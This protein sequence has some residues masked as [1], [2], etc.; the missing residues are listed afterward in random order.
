MIGK[1]FSYGRDS[2]RDLETR[3]EFIAK[4]YGESIQPKSLGPD[5]LCQ[6]FKLS[7]DPVAMSIDLRLLIYKLFDQHVISRL[8]EFY[9]ALNNL[10]MS[11]GILPKI[12]RAARVS[13]KATGAQTSTPKH[14]RPLPEAEPATP[15][16]PHAGAI[17]P[18]VVQT[19]PVPAGNIVGNVTTTNLLST[20]ESDVTEN[21]DPLEWATQT[22]LA[23]LLRSQLGNAAPLA[24]MG[25]AT[26]STQ[27]TQ[28]IPGGTTPGVGGTVPTV[29]GAGAQPGGSNIN[30]G[31]A[32]N[33]AAGQPAGVQPPGAGFLAGT[34]SGQQTDIPAKTPGDEDEPLPLQDEVQAVEVV[35][36]FFKE[37]LSDTHITKPARTELARLKL[38]IVKTALAD[39]DFFRNP[40]HP[41]RAV[42]HE[43]AGLGAMVRDTHSPAYEQISS[44]VDKLINN[45]SKGPEEFDKAAKALQKISAEEAKRFLKEE[46]KFSEERRKQAISN[47]KQVVR[48]KIDEIAGEQGLPEEAKN[49]VYKL[50]APYMA[51]QFL[52]HGSNSQAWEVSCN[53]LKEII[54]LIRGE[55][56]EKNQ[57]SAKTLLQ[58][59]QSA[60]SSADAAADRIQ[61][62]TDSLYKVFELQPVETDS[63]DTT[64]S[65]TEFSAEPIAQ[66]SASLLN[67]DGKTEAKKKEHQSD[68]ITVVPSEKTSEN[69]AHNTGADREDT[70]D[71][72][73]AGAISESTEAAHEAST[74]ELELTK[75]KTKRAQKLLEGLLHPGAWFRLYESNDKRPQWLR[76]AEYDDQAATVVLLGSQGVVYRYAITEFADE[77]I[78]GAC[79]PVMDNSEFEN[80]M[81]QV[82]TQGQTQTS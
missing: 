9:S 76:F 67:I 78:S 70:S 60:L 41:A 49:F 27:E 71:T 56:S 82:G 75:R 48:E 74:Q 24:T 57:A 31:L 14:G 59:M 73:R 10:L 34:G 65:D 19:N 17:D 5:K 38:P 47:A 12:R 50:W 46:K 53:Q 64:I 22:D 11:R 1:G 13:K 79:R 51:I 20:I 33:I 6:A 35:S 21:N 52:R 29:T 69:P 16:Y 54:D 23:A 2:I 42:M 55:R 45:Y 72:D 32:G 58:N 3:L 36:R 39:L 4:E 63:A 40:Q 37:I 61:P 18:S 81:E 26:A 66:K 30:S 15:S 68:L 43:L 25:A 7:M 8:N 80:L 44:L 28:G 62:L 77:I